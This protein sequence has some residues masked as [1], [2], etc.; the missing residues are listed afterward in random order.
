MTMAEFQIAII[1]H[2]LLAS[3]FWPRGLLDRSVLMSIQISMTRPAIASMKA[4]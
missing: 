1:S 4:E 3:A 2:R